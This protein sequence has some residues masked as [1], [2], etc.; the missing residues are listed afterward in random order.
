MLGLA[1]CSAMAC[2]KPV[3]G[4][5]STLAS[6][7]NVP[8][9]VSPPVMGD[10]SEETASEASGGEPAEA[11]SEEPE[12]P[13]SA[14]VEWVDSPLQADLDGDG[15]PE[16][17]SWTCGG[18]LGIRVGRARVSE[19]YHLVEERD[20]SAGLVV[21]Q[22][23]EATR[24]LVFTIDE[25]EEVGPDLHFLY[26]YREGK[27]EQLWTDKV[28]L[29]FLV[30]G[31]WVTE[32]SECYEGAGYLETIAGLHRWDGATVTSEQSKSRTPVEPGDCAEP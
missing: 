28:T 30:D 31:S 32:T 24:Q 9:G 17:I 7:E 10:A 27:L 19:A 2:S 15:K 21:L 29:D 13:A 3:L 20:C 23:S 14:E 12:A 22:P 6:V 1:V 26:A 8:A 4:N 11:L 25:H 5:A 18:T 16:S